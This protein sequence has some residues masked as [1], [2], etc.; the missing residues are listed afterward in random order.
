M[1]QQPMMADEFFCW[2]E[3]Q[4]DDRYELVDGRPL[5]MAGASIAQDT[6]VMNAKRMIGNQLLG[7]PCS[8]H[9][10]DIAIMIPAGNIRYPD[11]SVD[12]GTPNNSDVKCD[13]PTLVIEVAKSTKDFDDVVKLEEYKSISSMKYI[14]LVSADRPHV[15]FFYLDES[16]NWESR[17][18]IGMESRI[19]TEIGVFISL[20]DL[21]HGLKFDNDLEDKPNL[22]DAVGSGS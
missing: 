18:V 17:A 7:K 11:L 4:Q 1:A 6:I 9:S 22:T 19:E 14:L 8:P 5:M 15:R 3:K 10:A 20:G 13:I 21:Y 2:L 16:G 12:C